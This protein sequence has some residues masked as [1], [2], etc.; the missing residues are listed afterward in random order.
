MPE[1]THEKVSDVKVSVPPKLSRREMAH[2]LAA[3]RYCQ[4][5]DLS[6][7]PHFV[8]ENFKPLNEAEVD[9][10]CER[11]NSSEFCV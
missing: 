6:S 5:Y 8:D 10:L 1:Q 4:H 3:L 7:M 11:L 9:T 2:V